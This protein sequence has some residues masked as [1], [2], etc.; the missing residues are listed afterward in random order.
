MNETVKTD[1]PHM[2]MTLDIL[3]SWHSNDECST[4]FPQASVTQIIYTSFS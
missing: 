1:V 2:D 4:K 3:K